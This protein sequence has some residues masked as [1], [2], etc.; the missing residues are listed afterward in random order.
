[1]FFRQLRKRELTELNIGYNLQAYVSHEKCVLCLFIT[2][3]N[4]KIG[5]NIVDLVNRLSTSGVKYWTVNFVSLLVK[6]PVIIMNQLKLIYN[7]QFKY[8][9]SYSIHTCFPIIASIV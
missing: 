1:M 3:N 5:V 8:S 9:H 2:S 6:G 4:R 7:S